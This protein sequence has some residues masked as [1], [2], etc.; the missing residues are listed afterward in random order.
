MS[1]LS[2]RARLTVWYT[3]AL[4][5]VLSLF[6]ADVLWQLGRIGV[7]RVD[8]ALDGVTATAI[9]VLVAELKES[10]DTASA[11]RETRKTVAA[12]G[13]AVAILDDRGAP[14]A[15]AWGGLALP[16]AGRL[17][18][19]SAGR[20]VWTAE[21]ASGTWRVHAE[22]HTVGATTIVVLTG[23]PL[24]DVLRERREVQEAM[25]V[26]IPI[27]LLLAGAGGFW[28]ASIGLRPITN[29]ARRAAR[30][31]A[32]GPEDLGESDRGDE[33]GQ[34]AR[35][36]NGLVERLRATLLTQRQL[37]ADASHELRTP[38]SVI[39]SAA[40]ITLARPSR[41]ESEYRE[42][43]AIVGA[44]ANRVGRLV[45]GMLVLAR[46]DAGAYPLRPVDLDVEELVA[47][48]LQTVSLLAAERGVTLQAGPVPDV[49]HVPD[50]PDIPGTPEIPEIP[51]IPIR[52]D[53]DLLRR[54][55]LNVV[56]NA[57]QHTPAGGAVRIDLSANT[58]RLTIRVRDQ[59][60]GIA[61][62]DRRRIFDRFVQLD[63]ARRSQGSGLGLPIARWIAEV[64]GGSL[65]LEASGDEG[66]TFRIELPMR[67]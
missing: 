21:T 28:L 65:D 43:L 50:V 29:M 53:E 20:Q 60:P 67:H 58:T 59:G 40:E 44:E 10:A 16:P 24:S 54:M 9:N 3:L 35:A 30:L 13:L 66:S 26:G 48:C 17:P 34:L 45:E 18:T 23:A 7:R 1:T 37:M 49:P 5:L 64:H 8:R 12:P 22:P 11:A 52:G 56:Q 15:A 61:E 62:A 38:V 25:W 63:P 55:L 6:G 14:L 47:E 51:G 32:A 41:D 4:L 19:A 2:I 39:R 31:D 42:A 27:V 33:L 36:F 57:V 46:A